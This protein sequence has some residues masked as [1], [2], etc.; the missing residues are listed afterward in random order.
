MV[1]LCSLFITAVSLYFALKLEFRFSFTDVLPEDFPSVQVLNKVEEK[2]GGLGKLTVI[3]Q[4][5]WPEANKQ[6]VAFLVQQLVAHPDVN[7]LDYRKEKEFFDKNKLLYIELEDLQ[8]IQSR[9]EA[10][11]WAEKKKYNP[12]LV[13][14]LNE[15]E[16][17]QSLEDNLTFKDLEEKYFPELEEYLKQEYLG[18]KDE[19]SLILHI[20]PKFDVS[21]VEKCRAFHEDVK[22]AVRQIPI[23]DQIHIMYTGEVMKSLQEEGRMLSEIINSGWLSF[24]TILILLF[25]FFFR[26]PTGPVLALIPMLMGIIW[27]M[28][29]TY[30]FVGYLSMVTLCLGIILLGLGLDAA[31][32]LLSRYGEERRKNLSAGIAFE[33]AILE[34]GPAVSMGAL[35]SAA[36]FFAIMITDFKGFSEFGLI[37][38]IGMLCTL[39]AILLVFPCIL[40]ILEPIKLVSVFGPRIFNHNQFVRSSYVNWKQH[41]FLLITACILLCHQGFQSEFEYNF[42]RLGFPNKNAVAD[43][44]VQASG[45]AIASPAVVITPSREEAARVAGYIREYRKRDT[46]TP[47]IHSVMALNDLLPE[48]QEEKL[49]IIA[50]LKK[51]VT[52]RIITNAREPLKDLLLKLQEAW[53]VNMLT[54]EDLP[55]SFRKKFIGKDDKPGD[56]TFIFPSV[57][58]RDGL[59]CVAFADDTRILQLDSN[60]TYHTSGIAVI[61]ADLLSLMIPD[62]LKAIGLA[63][64]TVFI[65]I[66]LGTKTLRGTFILFIPLVLGIL[67]TLGAMKISGIKVNYF[68][69]MV[70]PAMIGIGID[71]SVH[72]YHRY[73]EE[74]LGSLYFVINRTGTIITVTSLTSMAGFFG[75]VFSG[76]RGLFSMGITAVIG[77]GLTLAASLLFVPI[78]LGYYDVKKTSP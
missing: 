75:L 39:V 27:A 9:I 43:S 48:D 59:N 65:L 71:N 78:V 7:I 44:I 73:L 28:A 53:D 4:S 5:E 55:E 21:D 8:E 15:E 49:E 29:L 36:A 72:L 6:A 42:D 52:Q 62:T 12:L 16:K 40:I 24:I 68:N 37:A 18:S 57:D 1:V 25:V 31:L 13:D 70:L 22:T 17:E 76:H 45:E 26:I 33:T 3:I 50:N 63:L 66:L 41:I 60:T 11:F 34:T 14:L 58:L 64:V 19:K 20:F 67:F 10:G 77:I 69:L 30:F 32:H 2:F 38:G 23:I 54:A 61:Y 56:F 47:T 51:M 74:G 35:T 46:L